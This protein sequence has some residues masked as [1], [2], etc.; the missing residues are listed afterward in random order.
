MFSPHCTGQQA[1]RDI[2]EAAVSR[3]DEVIETHSPEANMAS[4]FE[5]IWVAE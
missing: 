5:A 4:T 2:L 3:P 1:Q